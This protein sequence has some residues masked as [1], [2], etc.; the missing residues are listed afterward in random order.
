MPISQ[1]LIYELV[2][3][4]T[5]SKYGE[6]KLREKISEILKFVIP[7]IGSVIKEKKGGEPLVL[8]QSLKEDEKMSNLFRQALEKV[9]RPIVIYVASKFMNNQHLGTEIVKEALK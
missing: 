4:Y 3:G 1:N 8:W 6:S 7:S 2:A 5:Q 9:E